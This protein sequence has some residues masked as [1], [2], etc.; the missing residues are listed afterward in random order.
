MIPLDMD[1][2]GDSDGNGAEELLVLGRETTG[3]R[4]WAVR[5]DAASNQLLG[6]YRQ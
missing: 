6:V 2:C 5:K 1:V 3:A 4:L